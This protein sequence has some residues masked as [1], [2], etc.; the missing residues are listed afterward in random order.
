MRQS[1]LG[2]SA[3][4]YT[5]TAADGSLWD[6]NGIKQSV[7][8]DTAD[9]TYSAATLD[10]VLANPGPAALDPPR[11]ASVTTGAHAATYKTGSTHAIVVTGTYGGATVTE[12]LLLT[13]A[14]G[15]ETIVGDQPF[16]TIT[17]IFVPAQNDA[18]G[19]FQ[20]GVD[21]VA[22]KM[23]SDERLV[24]RAVRANAA[25][26]VKMGFET[27][28]DTVAFNSH[29]LLPVAPTRIYGTPGTDCAVMIFE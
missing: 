6:L 11:Y 28:T 10:G 9:H 14:G 1:D 26:N 22:S 16:D 13:N 5:Y 7:A 4:S 24:F 29:E 2:S 12:N 27:Y 23:R 20:F 8:T 17:S 15:G 25:G 19:T 18:L 21:G 3:R